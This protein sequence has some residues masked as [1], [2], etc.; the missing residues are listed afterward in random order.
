[1]TIVEGF[2]PAE[3]LFES[4]CEEFKLYTQQSESSGS[5]NVKKIID[6]EME[7]DFISRESSPNSYVQEEE[8]CEEFVLLHCHSNYKES[9][10]DEDQNACDSNIVDT[11]VINPNVPSSF[12]YD[13]IVV[14]NMIEDHTVDVALK[15]INLHL[16]H[17]KPIN[18]LKFMLNIMMIVKF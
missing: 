3:S 11:F 16:Y 7:E 6:E 10:N 18:V 4:C 5:M 1:M 14:P 15:N 17:L 12:G 2:Y 8:G 13:A 9:V